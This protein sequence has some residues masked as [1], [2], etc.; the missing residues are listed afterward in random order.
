MFRKLGSLNAHMSRTHSE[1]EVSA[2]SGVTDYKYM[3]S[4]CWLE[5]GNEPIHFTVKWIQVLK[6]VD[7]EERQ[8]IS[9]WKVIIGQFLKKNLKINLGYEI[10]EVKIFL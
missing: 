5:I 6:K 9:T 10:S 7:E 3:S 1:T 8:I 2:Q 4:V